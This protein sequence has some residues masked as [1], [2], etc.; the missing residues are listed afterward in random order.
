MKNVNAK[1][2]DLDP[3]TI[4]IISEEEGAG[5]EGGN[6]CLSFSCDKAKIAGELE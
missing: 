1:P 5:V 4:S 2:L 6:T 3:E